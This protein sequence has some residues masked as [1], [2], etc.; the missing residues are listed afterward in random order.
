VGGPQAAHGDRVAVATPLNKV[1][2]HQFDVTQYLGQLAEANDLSL[3]R[4]KD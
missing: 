1:M 2:Q 3:S 4:V